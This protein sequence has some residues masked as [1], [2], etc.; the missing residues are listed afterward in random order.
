MA[1]RP[2]GVWAVVDDEGHVTRVYSTEVAALRTAVK[3][4]STA[5]YMEYGDDAATAV[6]K[7]NPEPAPRK[8][9][10]AKAKVEAPEPE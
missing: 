7:G 2:D 3:E 6:K 8:P 4:A 1:R 5:V 10:T 9:R